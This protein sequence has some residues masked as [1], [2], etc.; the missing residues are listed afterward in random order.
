[1]PSGARSELVLDDAVGD[2][3][4]ERARRQGGGAAPAAH[5]RVHRIASMK[6]ASLFA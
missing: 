3:A 6:A 1:V 5:V 4:R 2:V